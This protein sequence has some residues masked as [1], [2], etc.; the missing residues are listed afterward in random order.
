MA[1][2]NRALFRS[3]L[4]QAIGSRSKSGFAARSGLAREYVSRLCTKEDC[5]RPSA[6]TLFKIAENAENGIT[7]DMLRDAC[8][9]EPLAKTSDTT[10]KKE[11]PDATDAMTDD[12]WISHNINNLSA[13]LKD[14]VPMTA[15]YQGAASFCEIFDL[16]YKDGA[17]TRFMERGNTSRYRGPEGNAAILISASWSSVSRWIRETV[18]FVLFGHS[19]SEGNFFATSFATDAATIIK[20]FPEEKERYDRIGTGVYDMPVVC[21]VHD[22]K[23]PAERLLKR[24]FGD[25][26]NKITT[27]V[28]GYGIYTDKGEFADDNDRVFRSFVK[29]HEDASRKIMGADFFDGI[30]NGSDL[31]E[32]FG[33][34]G[35]VTCQEEF[36]A[37]VMSEETGVTFEGWNLSSKDFPMNRPFV[38]HNEQCGPCTEEIERIVEK[39]ARE[40]HVPHIGTCW[41]YM[42]ICEKDILYHEKDLV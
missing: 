35:D 6:A 36:I 38:I 40:L 2:Y 18:D 13:F 32:F 34:Y 41:S 8:G 23:K 5:S 17:D 42:E 31:L 3:L 12:E 25:D 28:T 19:D 11:Q 30:T 37:A 10:I 4:I 33:D 21:F 24:I 7:I 39:Y 20:A 22:T 16:L 15:P 9:Y 26:G 14:A 1:E 29:N 27:L